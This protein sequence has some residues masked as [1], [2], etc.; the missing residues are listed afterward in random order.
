MESAMEKDLAEVFT[1]DMPTVCKIGSKK[2]NVLLDDLLNDEIE[3]FG[4]AESLEMQRVHFKT[5]DLEKIEVGS[6]L[7]VKNKT[8]I[9]LSSITSADG[10]E[11][12]VTVRAD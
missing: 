7:H 5:T 10:N 2:F 3:G 9:V 1:R 12:I 4:G 8:K 6:K 11:L